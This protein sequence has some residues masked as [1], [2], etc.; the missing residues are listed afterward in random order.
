[1]SHII[2]YL[3][4]GFTYL[5]AAVLNLHGGTPL[6]VIGLAYITMAVIDWWGRRRCHPTP[7][8]GRRNR[9]HDVLRR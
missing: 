6:A 5:T 8:R 2:I 1:M 7:R 3:T 4:M 9:F